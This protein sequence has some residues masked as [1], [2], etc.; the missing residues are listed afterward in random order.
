[1]RI[2]ILI[3]ALLLPGCFRSLQVRACY[4]QPLIA[5]EVADELNTEKTEHANQP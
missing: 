4:K 5:A 1:M 2:T 3:I